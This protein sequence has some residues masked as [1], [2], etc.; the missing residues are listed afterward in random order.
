MVPS[1][2]YLM[3]RLEVAEDAV[4]RGYIKGNANRSRYLAELHR[5]AESGHMTESE[6]AAEVQAAMAAARQEHRDQLV[7]R[8]SPYEAPQSQGLFSMTATAGEQAANA[9]RVRQ[10]G[11]TWQVA[12]ARREAARQRWAA[13]APAGSAIGAHERA[14]QSIARHNNSAW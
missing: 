14:L 12:S 1:E 6:R 8:S 13:A 3:R 5:K 2:K 7:G 9:N 10:E 4:R 11:R